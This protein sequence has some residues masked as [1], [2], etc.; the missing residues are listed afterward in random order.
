MIQKIKN[1]LKIKKEVKDGMVN[2]TPEVIEKPT[3]ALQLAQ[4]KIHNE[5][6]KRHNEKVESL[7]K[8][9]TDRL[10]E[11]LNT[12]FNN[13]TDDDQANLFAYDLLNK[14]WKTYSQ[15]A[16]TSQKVL[17]LRSNSF[18]V[19]VAR[20]VKENPQFQKDKTVDLTKLK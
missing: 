9:Y 3:T 18:E 2:S 12:Y 16:N 11:Y 19:E 15:N 1:L 5:R 14:E 20:I 8:H 13:F 6:V 10:N 7:G 4:E 17:Q